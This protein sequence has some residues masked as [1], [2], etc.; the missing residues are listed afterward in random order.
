MAKITLRPH[1]LNGGVAGPGSRTPP[2]RSVIRGWSLQ[3]AR[4]NR[5]FLQSIELG[6]VTGTGLFLTL[7]L[8]DLPGTSGDWTRIVGAFLERMRR[9]GMTRYHWVVEFQQ[10]G[11]PHLHMVA[12]WDQLPSVVLGHDPVGHWLEVAD[13]FGASPKGQDIR[14]CNQRVELLVYM[15]KHSART[16][17]HYQRQRTALPAGWHSVGR[18]WG[19]SSKGSWPTSVTTFDFNATAFYKLRRLYRGYRRAE[20]T[21]E[22]VKARG[23]GDPGQVAVAVGRVVH[24]RR[25]FRCHDRA[26]SRIKPLGPWI[27]EAAS[28]AMVMYIAGLAGCDVV[29]LTEDPPEP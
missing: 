5:Q 29:D 21:S 13:E 1:G 18:L 19:A 4:R 26:H 23:T 20:A 16:A 25:M 7:T 27:P 12:Y 6:K 15:A 11:V 17:D 14:W 24:A 28:S 8:R 3:A 2:K 9:T 10:R 22:L